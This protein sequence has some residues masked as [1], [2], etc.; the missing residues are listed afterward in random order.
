MHR[1]RRSHAPGLCNTLPFADP[2]P[3]SSRVDG[4]EELLRMD[5]LIELLCRCP[6]ID[7]IEQHHCDRVRVRHLMP[8]DFWGKAQKLAR[9]LRY[10]ESQYP[11]LVRSCHYPAP[12]ERE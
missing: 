4:T 11:P 3:T 7:S 5:A 9:E 6:S 8:G 1:Q 12:T 2:E 10:N